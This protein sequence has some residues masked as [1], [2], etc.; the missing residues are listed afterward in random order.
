MKS[1]MCSTIDARCVLRFSGAAA[2]I[3][4][5]W[6]GIAGLAA[7]AEPTS[8]VTVFGPQSTLM[9]AIR[10]ADVQI[11]DAGQ[12]FVIVRGRTSGFVG[13]LYSGGAWA[14]LP[15]GIGACGE[16]KFSKRNQARAIG[17]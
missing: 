4:A 14:V 12:G 10:S 1:N 3:L 5:I 13:A 6:A 11:L 17:T 8:T 9:Q 2:G 16:V 7:F 15:G